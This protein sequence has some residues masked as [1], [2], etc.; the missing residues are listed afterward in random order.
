MAIL[1]YRAAVAARDAFNAKDKKR[2]FETLSENPQLLEML[3]KMH[4]AQIGLPLNVPDKQARQEGTRVAEAHRA[5]ED[6]GEEG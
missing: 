6:E 1:D 2:A 5:A 3:S 4:R